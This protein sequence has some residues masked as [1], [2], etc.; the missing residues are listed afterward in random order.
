M[1]IFPMLVAVIF[2]LPSTLK[3][4]TSRVRFLNYYEAAQSYWFQ[5]QWAIFLKRKKLLNAQNP[6]WRAHSEWYVQ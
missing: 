5:W 2:F 6:A 1:A 4:E 3:P